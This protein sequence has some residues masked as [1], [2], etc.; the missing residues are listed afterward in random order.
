MPSL[1]QSDLQPCQ[2][3]KSSEKKE[4]SKK[5]MLPLPQQGSMQKETLRKPKVTSLGV[6]PIRKSTEVNNLNVMLVGSA[7][8]D[9]PHLKSSFLKQ[10]K[11]EPS[12]FNEV[13]TQS[14]TPFSDKPKMPAIL[15]SQGTTAKPGYSIRARPPPM[16]RSR[17]KPKKKAILLSCKSP[18]T[19]HTTTPVMDEEAQIGIKNS[20]FI[21]C[22]YVEE[23][24][25]LQNF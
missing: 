1:L 10:P 6:N 21:F 9:E 15:S 20:T 18:V 2:A 16:P 24:L 5:I 17:L 12:I 3:H 23:V 22:I 7:I 25:V 13:N 8:T 19:R 4:K 14:Q 11:S